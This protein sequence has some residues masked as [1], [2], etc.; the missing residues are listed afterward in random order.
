VRGAIATVDFYASNA[1][2]ASVRL[3]LVID[4]P[5]R[6]SSGEGWQCRVALADLYRPKTV[7]GRDS[8]EALSLALAEARIWIAEL[9]TQGWALTR[10]R[11][12]KNPFELR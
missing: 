2:E 5:Q 9:C 12:G 7:V 3:S 1:E 10:D 11:A 6:C 4:S 8:I